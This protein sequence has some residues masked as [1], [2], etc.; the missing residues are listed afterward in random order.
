MEDY[1]LSRFEREER[2][3]I[4]GVVQLAAKACRLFMARDIDVTMSL[5]NSC[6]LADKEEKT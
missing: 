6:N 1:V 3:I 5:T 4:S 2:E